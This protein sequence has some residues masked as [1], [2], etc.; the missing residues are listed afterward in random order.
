MPGSQDSASL[1]RERRQR[2][3]ESLVAGEHLDVIVIGGGI[4]G[5][6]AALDAAARG[7][8]VALI[9][10]HDLA[11]GTSSKSSR[12]VHGGLRYLAHGDLRIAWESARERHLLMTVVAPHLTRPLPFV[13]PL[14][15]EF[16]PAQAAFVRT[17]LRAADVLRRSAGTPRDLLPPARRIDAGLCRAL[18]PGVA[19]RGL[20]GGIVYWDGQLHDDARLVVA[21]ARTAAA[22]GARILTYCDAQLVDEG[23]VRARDLLSGDSFELSASVVINAAGVWAAKLTDAV[24][25]RPSKGSHVLVDSN[26]LGDP[27]AAIQVPVPGDRRRAVLAMPRPDGRVLIGLTDLPVTASDRIEP[28]PEE[29]EFLL[30]AINRP[31]EHGL[32]PD[33]IVGSYAGLRPLVH[34]GR[35]ETTD[36]SRQH[37]VIKEPERRLVTVIGGK[38]TTYRAM[39]EDGIDAA[40]S[41]IGSAA[42]PTPTRRLALVGA[43]DRAALRDLRFAP[44][45][46]ERYGTEASRI[47]GAD[48]AQSADPL[49]DGLSASRAEAVFA[50]RHEGALT[51]ED[52]VERRLGLGAVAEERA[53]ALAAVA[54]LLEDA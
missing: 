52:V 51:P 28:S 44:R 42:P 24:R 4:T 25:L 21:V 27:R 6:G 31:L 22:R 17:L 54:Q 11:S 1:N 29:V 19:P 12:L 8:S 49:V 48:A 47:G 34:D 45:L 13:G 32:V 39:A 2:D 9:E 14:T 40:L 33:D 38:L 35:H 30:D 15:N 53:A 46:I 16:P 3:L 23:A 36:L 43:A 18:A 5:V 41:L 20:R 26:R 7:L 37:A 10:R 50:V